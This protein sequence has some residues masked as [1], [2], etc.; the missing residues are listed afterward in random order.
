MKTKLLLTLWLLPFSITCSFA[1]IWAIETIRDNISGAW[2]RAADFDLDGDPDILIQAG[3]SILWYENLRPGWVE[4]L[5]DPTFYNSAYAW[6]DAKDLDG[7]GDMDVLK[8][9]LSGSGSDS[10]TW[11]ENLSNGT[12]WEKHSILNTSNYIGWM[13][14]SYGDLDGDGDL[15]IVVPEYF[16]NMGRLYWLENIDNSGEYVQH[17]LKTGDHNYSSVADLDGDGDLDIVSALTD[18]F[19]L[20]NHLPDTIWTQHQVEAPGSSYHIIGVCSDLN[21]DNLPEII[22]NPLSGSNDKVV[23]YTNPDWQAVNVNIAPG[24]L[25]GEIGD[26]DGDG[27][28][29]VTYGGTGFTG[30]P[31]ALGWA[32]N[33][34]NGSNWVLHDITPAKNSQMFASGLADFDGDGDL[35]MASL[36]FDVNTTAGSVFIAYNPMFTTGTSSQ[37][38]QAFSLSISPNPA[39]AAVTLLVQ[40]NSEEVF[41]IEIFDLNGRLVKALEMRGGTAAAVDLAD[42]SAG[43]YFVKVFNEKILTIW[44]LIKQ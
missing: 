36:D 10:L 33:Q 37:L 41:Q 2:T 6:V 30:I 5:V 13:Q 14:G 7:D 18:V 24:V 3:D 31:Q 28:I 21:G 4:H 35:D 43:S 27:D 25:L 17:P 20:E 34:N 40:A 19:W 29:D 8:A 44:K 38:N 12:V 9:P 16:G 42:M 26:I 39:A 15:D 23:Y 1:Q 11:N 32:E 22:S